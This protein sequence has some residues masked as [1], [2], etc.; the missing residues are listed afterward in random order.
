MRRGGQNTLTP[1]PKGRPGEV[2]AVCTPR[3]QAWEDHHLGSQPPGLERKQKSAGCGSVG[4]CR[5]P[6]D[7]LQRIFLPCLGLPPCLGCTAGWQVGKSPLQVCSRCTHPQEGLVSPLWVTKRPW[8]PR[9]LSLCSNAPGLPGTAPTGLLSARLPWH[10]RLG[11]PPPAPGDVISA[12]QGLQ[13]LPPGVQM[14]TLS[15]RAG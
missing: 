12:G 7:L 4:T 8:P 2:V 11:A 6:R 9:T 1:P 14:R 10:C 3:R 13:G 15:P 5:Q